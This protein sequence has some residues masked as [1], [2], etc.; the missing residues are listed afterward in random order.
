MICPVCKGKKK[1]SGIGC[2]SQGCRPMEMDCFQCKGTGEITQEMI[3]WIA[4]GK[5]IREQRLNRNISSRE[6]AKRLNILP[7][8]YSDIEIGRTRNL[9]WLEKK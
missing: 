7:S 6:E 5:K 8:A 1:S 4:M 9:E 2:G 3:K